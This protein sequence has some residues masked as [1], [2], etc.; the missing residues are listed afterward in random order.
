MG[1]KLVAAFGVGALLAAGVFYFSA[2]SKSEPEPKSKPAEVTPL[3]I[4]SIV[5]A[6]S[7]PEQIAP[8]TA[9]KPPAIA[10][11]KAE[12]R[13]KQFVA[14]TTQ[15]AAPV[16]LT[17]SNI[18]VPTLDL[19]VEEP[20]VIESNP[21]LPPPEPR[22]VILPAGALIQVRLAE[23]LATDRNFAGDAFAAVLDRELVV[24]GWVIAEPGA[25]VYGK[26][27]ELNKAGR[28]KGI[29]SMTLALTSITTSDGQK[30]LIHT[31]G[32]VRKGDTSHNSDAAMIALGAS[33][34]AVIGGAAGGGAG[35]AI[36]AGA[37]GAAGV[38][39]ALATRGKAAVLEVETRLSLR[40]D[41][42][43]TITERR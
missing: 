18:D 41:D 29:A 4:P 40:L 13:R 20:P 12:P 27:V 32:F 16:Q 28:V 37:G 33:L 17:S 26:I 31:V 23:R 10:P 7:A 34:G 25:R 19:P 8:P 11:R 42:P 24:D 21:Q 9:P 43:V 35:A 5:P 39:A 36:G 14:V 15:L 2:R 6:E 30:V 1:S 3:T 38:G 22:T